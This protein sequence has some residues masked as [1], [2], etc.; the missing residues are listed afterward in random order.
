M[1]F[2]QGQVSTEGG[3]FKRYIG[4]ASV[5][6]LAINPT[7]AELEKLEQDFRSNANEAS[8]PLQSYDCGFLRGIATI[9]LTTPQNRIPLSQSMVTPS[10]SQEKATA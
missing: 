2:G 8:V 6:V 3:S 7:K 10:I 9:A 5:S 4:V 1:A